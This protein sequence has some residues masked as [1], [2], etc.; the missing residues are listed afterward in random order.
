MQ[1]K[2]LS[3]VFSNTIVKKHQFFGLSP[4]HPSGSSQCTSPEHP[5]SCIAPGLA[6]CFACDNLHR[7]FSR[8]AA[9]FSSYDGDLRLPLGL[10]LGSPIFPSSCEGKLVVAL[11]H[12]CCLQ[13][14]S[15]DPALCEA[16]KLRSTV[17]F[18]S[19]N[20]FAQIALRTF[21]P[22]LTLRDTARAALPC[23]APALPRLGSLPPLLLAP[24]REANGV[25]FLR[26]DEA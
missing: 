21:G 26:Q 1:S 13:P 19:P 6:I 24:L 18:A 15:R 4:S 14:F 17:W 16:A 23:P 12:L 3:R 25:P 11:G 2:G 9:A 8:V 10:A 22:I 5:V 7:G 20:Y